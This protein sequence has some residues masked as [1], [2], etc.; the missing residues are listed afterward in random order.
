MGDLSNLKT[1]SVL[2]IT[3]CAISEIRGLDCLENLRELGLLKL[4]HVEILPDL[5]NLNKL[6]ALAVSVCGNLVE[7]QGELPPSLESLAIRECGSLQKLLDLS[8][9]KGLE[10]FKIKRC[11]KLNVEAISSLCSEEVIFVGDDNESE[12]EYDFF[13]CEF[14]Y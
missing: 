8:S 7:I 11:G 5:S 14:Q 3:N 6:A 12:G 1:L 10:I 13:D 2:Y 9:L 4:Q